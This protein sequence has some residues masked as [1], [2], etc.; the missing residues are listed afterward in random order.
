MVNSATV[1]N[2]QNFITFSRFI[3][4]YSRNLIAGLVLD[5]LV[6]LSSSFQIKE[7]T[8]KRKHSQQRENFALL[9]FPAFTK[10]DKYNA[11]KCHKGMLS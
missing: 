8:D 6:D 9:M 10:P 4:T 2:L 5:K 1:V 11:K 3:Y 7:S